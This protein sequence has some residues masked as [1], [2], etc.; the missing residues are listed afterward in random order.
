MAVFFCFKK[1]FFYICVQFKKSH[2]GYIRK[3]Y[4]HQNTVK[5]LIR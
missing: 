3:I 4:C 2:S 5:Q 1:H